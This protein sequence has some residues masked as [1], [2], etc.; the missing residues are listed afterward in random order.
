[1]DAAAWDARYAATD[2]VWSAEPNA[3]VAAE[4]AALAPGR[5]LDLAGGEGRNAIWLAESGWRVTMV[6]FSRVALEKA[7]TLAAR[8]DVTLDL[9]EADVT[10]YGPDARSFDLVLV[11]YLQTD[12]AARTEWLGRA[13]DALA[14]GGTLLIV[15]HDASNL[16]HG[17]GGPQDASVLAT[18]ADVAARIAAHDPTLTIERAEVVERTVDTP[19]GPCVA[20]DH[21]VR[22]RRSPSG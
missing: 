2:L 15:C 18:P 12:E 1:M 4:T 9:V 22:A 6:E 10:T 7:A 21:L 20:L 3:F 14:P 17:Y 13:A 11:A 19:D 5:A 16:E 8:R